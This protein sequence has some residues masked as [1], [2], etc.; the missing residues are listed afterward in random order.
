MRIWPGKTV[1]EVKYYGQRATPWVY[2][3]INELNELRADRPANSLPI[4]RK[5]DGKACDGTS[6]W[7]Y[8]LKLLGEFKIKSLRQLMLRWIGL[9][10]GYPASPRSVEWTAYTRPHFEEERVIDP[11]DPYAAHGIEPLGYG[12]T[13]PRTPVPAEPAAP[14][15][16]TSTSAGGDTGAV[17]DGRMA[18]STGP[19]PENGTTNGPSRDDDYPPSGEADM[20]RRAAREMLDSGLAAT[21]TESAGT[22]EVKRYWML[23]DASEYGFAA[24]IKD[25]AASS[26][27]EKGEIIF[28]F[29]QY[30]GGESGKEAVK[31][32]DAAKEIIDEIRMD[33]KNA[34]RL[35]NIKIVPFDPSKGMRSL[36]EKIESGALV[37]TFARNTDEV[38]KYMKEMEGISPIKP[39]YIDDKEITG[40]VYYPLFEVVT[41]ALARYFDNNTVADLKEIAL[42]IGIKLEEDNNNRDVWIFRLLP[43][44]K[45][46]ETEHELREY[47]ANKRKILEAA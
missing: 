31:F 19:A 33:P 45:R 30:L 12:N 14:G 8:S 18:T 37:F 9:D 4:R 46:F 3:M 43:A 32:F 26:Y 11:A 38:R 47:F 25:A 20:S 6:T 29:D 24:A 23:H 16:P 5:P 36:K 41:M 42:K 34:G 28:A 40:L 2:G 13:M 7:L 35:R 44:I 10:R 27:R 1:L 15:T 39:S 22:A 17:G 21:G